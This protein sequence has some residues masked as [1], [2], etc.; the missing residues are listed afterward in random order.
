M[1]IELNLTKCFKPEYGEYL[2]IKGEIS[3]SY[4]TAC[5]RT[6]E[7]MCVSLDIGFKSCFLDKKFEEDEAFSEQLEIFEKNEL[8]DLYFYEKGLPNLAEMTHE[9]IYLNIN[10][11]PIKDPDAPL[12]DGND[13]N[14]TK[15]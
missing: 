7:D 4:V 10:Q 5:V 11:Y 14:S 1:E 8:Y 13:E 12:L 2:L 3:T 9:V 6:L 15:H